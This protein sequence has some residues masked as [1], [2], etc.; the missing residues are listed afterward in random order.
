M[1]YPVLAGR[2]VEFLNSEKI[3][4]V[5]YS[6]LVKDPQHHSMKMFHRFSSD[7]LVD[8]FPHTQKKM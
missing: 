4:P 6:F 3:M 1:S 8:T 5:E 2:G 7:V